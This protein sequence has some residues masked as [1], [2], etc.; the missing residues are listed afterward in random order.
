MQ[1]KKPATVSTG[2][3]N[4]L[5]ACWE[6]DETAGSVMY[7]SHNS[8]D[9][10]ISSVTLNQSG[11]IG[12][13]YYF[14]GTLNSQVDVDHHNDLNPG[15]G[16]FSAN[17]WVKYDGPNL[18]SDSC[19]IFA[20]GT[21]GY[22]SEMQFTL[23]GGGGYDYKNGVY[24]RMRT[25]Y[26]NFNIGPTTNY[27]SAIDDGEWHM[28]TAVIDPSITYKGKLYLDGLLIRQITGTVPNIVNTRDLI[29]GEY[30][31][32][33]NMEGWIDQVAIWGRALSATDITQLYNS[34]NGLAYSNW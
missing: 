11:V 26:I 24:F 25:P 22:G 6:M 7:D 28:I 14:D 33:Y 4:D 32:K 17:A 1:I 13:S 16:P 29:I 27:T 23:R 19:V 20:K 8:H 21:Y 15:T 18:S 34:G 2:L 30:N 10:D 5:I 31:S 9:G 12:K 3:L